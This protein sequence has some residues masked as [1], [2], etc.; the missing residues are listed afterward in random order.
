MIK[1][2]YCHFRVENRQ[3][4][5]YSSR[6]SEMLLVSLCSAIF[7]ISGVLP[8][9]G[10]L[11]SRVPVSPSG[12]T[13]CSWTPRS[14]C[15]QSWPLRIQC[16]PW[17]AMPPFVRARGWCPLWNLKSFPMA[18]VLLLVEGLGTLFFFSNDA[19]R[20]F[21]ELGLLFELRRS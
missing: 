6:V 16:T 15:P 19:L 4:F 17:P 13:C 5:T 3:Y 1:A 20:C 10:R 12:E 7:P 14:N 21:P 8:A 18:T 11:M 2:T 9:L